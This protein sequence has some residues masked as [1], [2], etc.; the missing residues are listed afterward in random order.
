MKILW[1][2]NMPLAP[3]CE[4][5]GWPIPAVG[6]WMYATLKNLKEHLEGEICVCSIYNGSKLI[7]KKIDN[8]QYYLL[9]LKGC[10][11]TKYNKHLESYWEKIH[12]DF[13]PDVVHIHGSEYPHGLAYVRSVGSKGV[14]VSIQGLISVYRRYYT[15]GLDMKTAKKCISPRDI[16]K[17]GGILR[18]K[19]EFQR[20]GFLERE[21][22][23][24][25][26]HV[27]GR[28]EWDK[29]HTWAIN[30]NAKYHYCGETLRDV[31][32]NKK[33]D[34][35]TCTPN[36]IFVSQASY[37]I[38]GL[39]ILLEAMP[40]V[41]REYPDAKINVAGNDPTSLPWWRITQYGAY[42]KRQ[43]AELKLSSNIEFLG[44][45]SESEMCDAYLNS[46]LF[47]SSST[48][49]NSPNSLGEAQLLSMP[50]LSSFVGGVPEIVNYS[51]DVLYRFDEPEM[52]AHKI[53]KVF[54]LKDSF[55]AQEFDEGRY[56]A[57]R[58]TGLLVSIYNDVSSQR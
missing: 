45:L 47:V 9:P 44:M 58:N 23:S 14:I 42:L 37:P 34:Y 43:I 3:I 46:N 52:L 21:L 50:H 32:Y 40:F 16:V 35:E 39:H 25:V 20:R 49:E 6:G 18:S 31:F 22:I 57:H 7:A 1:I 15:H 33:W 19:A 24:S 10:S 29:S 17:R 8:V 26:S 56:D 51:S 36:S 12:M 11:A 5:L 48:I 54:S 38:K 2:T 30:P 28:T 27:I 13:N 55:Q 41:L 53:C 4:E